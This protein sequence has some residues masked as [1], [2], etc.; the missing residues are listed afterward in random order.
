MTAIKRNFAFPKLQH[1]WSLSIRLFRVIIR[2]LV[3]GVLPLCREAVCVFYSPSLM[4][5]RWRSLPLCRNIV[6]VF[7]GPSRLSIRWQS[8][9]SAEMHSVC[10]TA[11]ADWALVG[12]VLPFCRDAV[13]IFYS[14]NQLGP[15]WLSLTPLQRCSRCILQPQPTEPALAES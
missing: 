13:G 15:R 6:G 14:P 12:W 5:P 3:G 2:T 11:P 8:Y 4:S 1:Y 9:S 10:S 7:Y